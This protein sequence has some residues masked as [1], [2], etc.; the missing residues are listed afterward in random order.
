MGETNRKIGGLGAALIGAIGL[1]AMNA[2]PAAAY[3]S[4]IH[5]DPAPGY[6]GPL[7]RGIACSYPTEPVPTWTVPSGVTKATFAL[8]GGDDEAA[9]KNGGSVSADLPV[10]AGQ[11]YTLRPGGNGAASSVEVGGVKVLVA[12]GAD[13]VESNYVSPSASDVEEEPPGTPLN[14]Y[15]LDGT[16]YILW[17]Q[18]WYDGRDGGSQPSPDSGSTPDAPQCVVPRLRGRSLRAARRALARANCGVVK[19]LLRPAPNFKRGRVIAQQPRPGAK[20]RET[21]PVRLV[22]GSRR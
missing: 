10:S 17:K 16:I 3:C 9:G 13:G 22:V 11:T 21:A 1:L 19:V 8:Y 7:T 20:L 6:V 18:G 5:A 2:A 15:A 12:G 4:T 14:G